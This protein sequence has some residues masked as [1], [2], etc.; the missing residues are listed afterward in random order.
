MMNNFKII[1]NIYFK[2]ESILTLKTLMMFG[3]KMLKSVI[4]KYTAN[5]KENI[6]FDEFDSI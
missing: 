4:F 2:T 6:T 5:T 1:K 3:N